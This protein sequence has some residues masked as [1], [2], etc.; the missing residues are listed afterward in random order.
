MLGKRFLAGFIAVVGLVLT[1]AH[2]VLMMALEEQNDDLV[3]FFEGSINLDD[4]VVR[5]TLT[6][7]DRA[8]I[9][10]TVG[11]ILSFPENTMRDA[12]EGQSLPRFGTLNSGLRDGIATGDG[13]GIFADDSFAVPAGYVSGQWIT[14]SMTIEDASLSTFGIVA[15]VYGITL[16][17]G[18]RFVLLAGDVEIVPIPGAAALFVPV[19]GAL[20]MRKRLRR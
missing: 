1:P 11:S 3:F 15:G 7:D 18:S 6:P 8:G 2:A 20:A 4:L 13:F 14:G 16:S 5:S 19:L 12:Y 9:G 10:A 17:N